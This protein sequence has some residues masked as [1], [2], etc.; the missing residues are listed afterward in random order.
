M[1]MLSTASTQSTIGWAGVAPPKRLSDYRPFPFAI[2]RV[3][4]NVVVDRPDS[5]QVTAELHL[6]PSDCEIAVPLV[7]RGVD[8]ELISIAFV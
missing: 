8:L 5:V 4:L 1:F 3:E 6:E 7:L 2:P